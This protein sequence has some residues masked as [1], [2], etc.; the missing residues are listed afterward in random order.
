LHE[1]RQD[2]LN[3]AIQT[4]EYGGAYSDPADAA[5]V[6]RHSDIATANEIRPSLYRAKD[7][8][9]LVVPTV[10][11]TNSVTDDTDGV[12]TQALNAFTPNYSGEDCSP[13]N[14]AALSFRDAVR[15]FGAYKKAA[16]VTTRHADG[17][18]S[19]GRQD[20]LS[21]V[22]S[23][24]EIR[25]SVA[26]NAKRFVTSFY[27]ASLSPEVWL[28]TNSIQ[29]AA[30]EGV[31]SQE[32]MDFVDKIVTFEPEFYNE[33][34]QF[35][36]FKSVQQVDRYTLESEIAGKKDPTQVSAWLHTD[37][38][39]RIDALATESKATL[40]LPRASRLR[41]FGDT[42]RAFTR[43]KKG[44]ST[45][46]APSYVKTLVSCLGGEDTA[47]VETVTGPSATE[48]LSTGSQPGP[49]GASASEDQPE[50]VS[51]FNAEEVKTFLARD[52]PVDPQGR[53]DATKIYRPIYE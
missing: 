10:D 45:Q 53:F 27:K 23:L 21:G 20:H 34:R 2:A 49:G 29:G 6:K 28:L 38:K 5:F 47:Q 46:V 16:K 17:L 42:L 35:G 33:F 7:G 24:D 44:T 13:V 51:S 8:K 14:P 19:T 18:L 32:V 11:S 40:I 50:L 39:A 36:D 4:L 26:L 48:A 12:R 22:K 37:R 31:S 43:P 1:S 3:K 25:P 52:G 41:R 15:A 30:L 9:F